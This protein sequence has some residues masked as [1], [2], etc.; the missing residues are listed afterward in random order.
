[1]DVDRSGLANNPEL[2]TLLGQG[3]S[4]FWDR[5]AERSRAAAEFEDV[6]FLSRL[7]KRAEARR[8]DAPDGEP[9]RVA[10]LDSPV[11]KRL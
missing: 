6:W 1:M 2:K 11:A 5:L 3:G 9:L 7:R 10:P 8:D 4:E